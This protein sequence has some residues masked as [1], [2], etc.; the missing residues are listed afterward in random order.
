MVCERWRRRS[1]V[2]LR[3]SGSAASCSDLSATETRESTLSTERL[4]LIRTLVDGRATMVRAANGPGARGPRSGRFDLERG[5]RRG[6]LTPHLTYLHFN[7]HFMER[8]YNAEMRTGTV[9]QATK[10]APYML[11]A[12]TVMQ[13]CCL[14]R[15][16]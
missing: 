10:H 8:V 16:T 4:N 15:S 12:Q 7:L 14:A 1:A 5:H 6:R 2:A 13:A 11:H 3:E 9:L